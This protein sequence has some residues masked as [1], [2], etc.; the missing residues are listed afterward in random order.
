M[1]SSLSSGHSSGFPS[2]LSLNAAVCTSSGRISSGLLQISA[3]SYRAV[4]ICS[5]T[6][7][8]VMRGSRIVSASSAT[9]SGTALLKVA[10]WYIMLSRE[11]AHWMFPPSVS[12]RAS[13]SSAE[14][15]EVDLKA[16]RSMM[17][18]TPRRESFS[19]RDPASTY[20]PT[21]ENEP[22]RASEATRRPFDSV[23]ISSNSVGSYSEKSS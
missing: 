15:L 1:T 9:V 20:T 23:V 14:C 8:S 7:S 22:G 6:S 13:I 2:V 16:N 4:S 12:T 21:P 11:D 10:A 18:E 5:A 19:N 3:I 17:W